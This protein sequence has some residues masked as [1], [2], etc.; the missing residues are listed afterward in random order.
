[1]QFVSNPGPTPFDPVTDPAIQPPVG[2][3]PQSGA[4]PAIAGSAGVEHRPRHGAVRRTVATLLLAVGLLAVG[5][6]SAVW[7]ASPDPSAA[8]TPSTTTPSTTPSDGATHSK[9]DCPGKGAGTPGGTNG[10]TSSP[11]TSG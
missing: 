3:A 6:A 5:G 1:M 8:T 2:S 11:S 4:D 7:A 10:S 9:G